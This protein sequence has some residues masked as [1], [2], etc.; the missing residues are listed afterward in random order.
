M[1]ARPTHRVGYA[2]DGT[3]NSDPGTPP[4]KSAS[5]LLPPPP[6][7]SCLPRPPRLLRTAHRPGQS[8]GSAEITH[9]FHPRRGQRFVVLKIRRVSGVEMLSLRDAA[10]GSFAVPRDWTDW[11][12]PGTS[13]EPSAGSPPLL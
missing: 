1:R 9:P 11:A 8:L 4:R 6:G 3:H 13:S 5:V 10:M 2:P 7:Q 12:P